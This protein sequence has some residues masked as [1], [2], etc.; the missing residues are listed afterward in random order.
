MSETPKSDLETFTTEDMDELVIG[1]GEMTGLD[2]AHV[3][4]LLE[5]FPE[6]GFPVMVRAVRATPKEQ[7][8]GLLLCLEMTF[9]GITFRLAGRM[10][11]GR[12]FKGEISSSDGKSSAYVNFD[13]GNASAGEP[14][15]R[16]GEI[17]DKWN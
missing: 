5:A 1:L 11:K 12:Y 13:Q 14:D 4:M 17:D 9:N 2:D 16:T 6:I 3:H 7:T 15:D 10:I 8:K